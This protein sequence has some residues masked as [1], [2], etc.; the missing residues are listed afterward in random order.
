MQDFL[1]QFANEILDS[2][3]YLLGGLGIF[4]SFFYYFKSQKRLVYQIQT[5]KISKDDIINKKLLT[6]RYF[7]KDNIN[8]TTFMIYNN[9]KKTIN[10]SDVSRLILDAK[11]GVIHKIE[12]IHNQKNFDYTLLGNLVE[13]NISYLDSKNYFV[14]KV[15]HSDQIFF[16]GRVNEYGKILN[17]ES[18]FWLHVNMI[19][20]LFN[21]FVLFRYLFLKFD[22][23]NI[24]SWLELSIY[25]ISLLIL[26]NMI[27][28]VHAIF[29]I[30]DKISDKY[31][32]R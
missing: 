22:E 29:F 8:E 7:I 6:N 16:Q 27:R 4:L 14:L 11:N 24:A 3:G 30:P 13:L 10:E 20:V 25:F 18:K 26:T 28:L 32:Q 31:F 17:Y 21:F 15:L 23:N 19:L 1:W 2:S 9:G 12:S 5:I